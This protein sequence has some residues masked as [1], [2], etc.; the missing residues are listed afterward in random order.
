MSGGLFQLAV[1]GV[2]DL[3]LTHEPEVTFFKN[4]FKRY[5]NFLKESIVQNF[6]G[7][8]DF[9][10]RVSVVISRH[11]DLMSNVYVKVILPTIEYDKT[12]KYI[13]SWVKNIGFKIIKTVEIEIG[14]QI[15]DKHYSDWLY[16]WSEL[17]C[18]IDKR[19]GLNQMIG[20]VPANYDFNKHYN[21]DIGSYTCYIPLYFWFCKSSN[22]ALPI[23]AL[24][25][26]EI[27]INI[28]FEEL[29]NCL[30]QANISD[31][32]TNTSVYTTE[33]N[34]IITG[35][36]VGNK[37][38]EKL[39]S[40]LEVDFIFL[41]KDERTMFINNTH[42]Y[43]IE[44]LQYNNEN[45]FLGDLS[46]IHLELNHPVK[47][48]IW[49][50]QYEKNINMKNFFNYKNIT[51]YKK[52]TKTNVNNIINYEFEYLT[53]KSLTKNPVNKINL[54]LNGINR[55]QEQT[56]S[57]SNLIQQYNY[58][59][60]ITLNGINS[61]SFALYPENI[62]PSGTCN[63]SMIDETIL[64]NTLNSY[65]YN[66]SNG[67]N[68]IIESGYGNIII[69]SINYNILKIKSGMGGILFSN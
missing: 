12:N 57:Y 14:G 54:M 9:G 2:E 41:D 65:Y 22:S 20:N 11:G 26:H 67:N 33:T 43:Y 35:V 32:I 48:I 15:I 28:E 24:K 27:K 8:V 19:D 61:F 69:A 45:M 40:N 21:S 23:I 29:K 62:D 55:F 47:E 63:F 60:N 50:F 3:I 1:Y 7:T 38:I 39:Q 10:R 16:I 44:Q 49:A 34:N 64:E 53:N 17:T 4:M 59:T 37:I 6:I 58:H 56:G 18:P 30:L 42:E 51:E 25:N 68:D 46:S 36:P 66:D 13:Y 52:I 31:I 5:S